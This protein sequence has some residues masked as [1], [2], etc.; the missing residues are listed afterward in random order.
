M[1]KSINDK[2][3]VFFPATTVATIDIDA[4]V[5]NYI[6]LSQH[7]IPAQCSAVVKANAY[8]LGANKIAPALYQVG[9]RT[10][11]VAKIEEALQLKTVLPE[12]VMIALLNGLPHATEELIAQS[13]IVPVLNSWSAIKD[14]QTLCQKKHKKFPAIIQIDTHMN[15]LGLDKK[16]LQELIRQPTIFEKAEIKYILS[17]LANGEDS[18]HPSN[19]IQ[20]AAFKAILAKLPTCKVSFAN[21]GGIFLGS[22]FHFDLVRPGIALYGVDPRE[23]HQTTLKPVLKL[24]AQVIQSRYVDAG[25]A[26]GYKESFVTCRPSTLATISIG[27]AD[28]WPRLLSN[29]GSVYFNGHALPIVGYISMDSIILDTT[30]L[31]KKPQRGDWVELI[32]PNQSVE[33]VARDANTIPNEILTSLGSRYQRIYLE[34]N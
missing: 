15:R 28:G 30:D 7:V 1:N 20:L 2:A 3:N 21:S 14:W 25:T 22:D 17:H 6:T 18:T 27:Y 4:I 26:V 9:C 10:F 8:G 19:A 29:K 12:N 33:K 24:Q 32:G 13:G 23:K 5:E 34:K 31:D 16:E 11:F